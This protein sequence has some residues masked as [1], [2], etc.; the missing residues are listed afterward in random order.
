[1]KISKVDHTRAGVRVKNDRNMRKGESILYCAPPPKEGNTVHEI[2]ER[3]KERVGDSKALYSILIK[4]NTPIK[5]KDL[6]FATSDILNGFNEIIKAMLKESEA[7]DLEQQVRKAVRFFRG[8]S[9]STFIC[10]KKVR[11]PKTKQMNFQKRYGSSYFVTAGKNINL[12]ETIK[13]I[14][15]N[16]TRS[17]LRKDITVNGEK[18]YLP[19]ILTKLVT[20]LCSEAYFSQGLS[21]VSDAELEACI[22][23]IM[24]DYRKDD[25]IRKT[26]VSLQNQNVKAVIDENNLLVP[27]GYDHRKKK[28]IFEFM[29]AYAAA[30]EEMKNEM[31]KHI[32]ALIVLFYCGRNAYEAACDY[33]TAW[34]F[35][36]FGKDNQQV[37]A[38]EYICDQSLMDRIN[39]YKN[40]QK[41]NRSKKELFDMKKELDYLV[42]GNY[43]D[44]VR[45]LKE[46]QDL[47]AEELID[48]R[49]LYSHIDFFWMDYIEKTATQLMTPYVNIDFGHLKTAYLCEQT[50]KIWSAFVAEKFIDYG[51]AVY[52]FT[53]PDLSGV[54]E[55]KEISIKGVR[56]EYKNGITSFDYERIKAEESLERKISG[57]LLFAI[58]NFSNSVS[59]YETRS[60]ESEMSED[61]LAYKPK[62]RKAL[63]QD[64]N[65]R[66]FQFFGGISQW[67]DQ[68]VSSA[69][70][71]ELY[72]AFQSQLEQ[73]RNGTFHYTGKAT[74]KAVVD[75][76][77]TELFQE[78]QKRISIM[79]GKK[80]YS[81]NVY[82]YYGKKEIKALESLLYQKQADRPA[83]I[84][85]FERVMSRKEFRAYLPTYF[86][87]SKEYRELQALCDEKQLK[88]YHSSLYFIMKEAYYYG[89]LQQPN[90]KN[91]FYTALKE[92]QAEYLEG[93]DSD[94]KEAI[95][96]F[97]DY[98]HKV[99][100][101]C[102]KLN[103]RMTLGDVCQ[104]M[105]TEYMLQNR[106][107]EVRA[108][109]PEK[110]SPD[111]DIY[112]HFKMCLY[113]VL[114]HAFLT[115]LAGDD[116]T[117][118]KKP[119]KTNV[120]KQIQDPSCKI[121]KEDVFCA[122]WNVQ[123]F[124]ALQEKMEK[125][126]NLYGWYVAG[127]FLHP[128]QLNFLIGSIKDYMQFIQ[129]IDRR[130][131]SVG[132]RR[133][134][135]LEEKQTTYKDILYVLE[136]VQN[137][138]GKISNVT[139]D[140][141]AKS[142]DS[143]EYAEF[144]SHFVNFK[145]DA[146]SYNDSLKDFCAR[147]IPK[148]PDVPSLGIYHNPKEQ[149]L[150][151][152]VVQARMYGNAGVIGKCMNPVHLA[153]IEKF[154]QSQKRMEAL[155][156]K[157]REQE[158]YICEEREQ[159]TLRGYQR[160][161]N[162]IEL[163]DVTEYTE[164]MNDLIGQL[165]SW[166]YLRERDMMYFQL[167]YYYT[168]LYFTNQIG[169]NDYRNR[170]VGNGINL[171]DGAILYQLIAIY[172]Y[173]LRVVRIN[174]SNGAYSLPDK[175]MEAGRSISEF[176]E[177][178]C[179]KKV[180]YQVLYEGMQLFEHK[181]ERSD[182][183]NTR[184]YID[185]FK[186]YSVGGR[187]ILDL[188]SEVYDRF[189][190]YDLKLKKSVS[191]VLSNTLKKYHMDARQTFAQTT[192][193]V[194]YTADG[195][196]KDKDRKAAQITLLDGIESTNFTYTIQ[197]DRGRTREC[198]LPV[199][200]DDYLEQMKRI[201]EAK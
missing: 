36:I 126:G 124:N 26:I 181:E 33:A 24:E 196:K 129:D 145:D 162:R 199:H 165:V 62:E 127:H 5:N 13:K 104:A 69:D 74:E 154:Y 189:F 92:T 141:F 3:V 4:D 159:K 67:K 150:N 137:F 144:L 10:S 149:I 128:K 99:E 155:I 61:I 29:K 84:P 139:E 143:Q 14:V 105:M 125:N 180:G 167:G 132:N 100:D 120:A 89:F 101:N 65:R 153:E 70:R 176:T 183:R 68:K 91:V 38:K 163:Y 177:S 97:K 32:R 201:L 58:N 102:K 133:D 193:K 186:Y 27:A 171:K 54:R 197:G 158:G 60:S 46:G 45:V 191:L 75:P 86:Y 122:E 16:N 23:A 11:D 66:L 81:N 94:R 76:I 39:A 103:I 25:M 31:L 135:G 78:E 18:V 198:K 134:S 117:F 118:L 188:Y 174:K 47:P 80:Y 164:C 151:R 88:Q 184:N 22:R 82:L 44:A 123:L 6:K 130:A 190:T 157:Q 195:E 147:K 30:D 48:N 56:D 152:N 77:I 156:K 21:S 20:A 83:Q 87:G 110:N 37:Y 146:K 161:K 98:Y 43:Q 140:Y 173:A 57:Y 200:S 119:L 136:F 64:L 172:T 192:R 79:F 1:M 7:P 166:S 111:K 179:S 96:D 93:R 55:G 28:Y 63:D 41:R 170:L 113:A 106:E 17:A 19:D 142:N 72:Y 34:S 175:G 35:G 121:I 185:H 15:Q 194:E 182:I 168:K 49:T 95:K 9:K 115:Y 107:S 51:K 85:S 116:W 109:A 8:Y 42:A 40:T 71:L 2:T 112:A 178:Y 59:P 138:I 169:E 148:C 52:H 160:A 114:R 73:L 12:E 53:V 131:A 108:E 187:S 50:W 90:L